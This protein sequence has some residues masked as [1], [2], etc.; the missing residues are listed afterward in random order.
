MAEL[1]QQGGHGLD[2]NGREEKDHVEEHAGGG[3]IPDAFLADEVPDHHL[4]DALVDDDRGSGEEK[5]KGFGE[6]ERN[7]AR[8][9]APVAE[10]A[11]LG[12]VG[13][14]VTRRE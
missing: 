12:P 6:Q 14:G 5:G 13:P 10:T 3:E 8:I 4:V 7:A 2:Q 1:H 11:D 9:E